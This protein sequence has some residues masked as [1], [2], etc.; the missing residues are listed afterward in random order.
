MT[1]FSNLCIHQA[2]FMKAWDFRQCVEGLARHGIHSTAVWI[3]KLQ[4]H[5]AAEDRCRVAG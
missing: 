1:D 5:T 3:E 4:Q 2:T